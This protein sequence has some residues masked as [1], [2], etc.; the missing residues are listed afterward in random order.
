[1]SKTVAFIGG[2]PASLVSAIKLKELRNDLDIFIIDRNEQLLKKLRMTGNGKCNIAPIKDDV[3]KYNNQN[4]V[5]KLFEAIPFD[6]YLR[7]LAEL[8]ILTK[9][10]KDYGYYPISES[11]PNVAEILINKCKRLGIKIINDFVSDYKI[12][13]D[14]VK[15]RGS[16]ENYSFDHLVIA[17]GGKSHP[18]TG[19][20]GEMFL[21]L[22]KHGYKINPLVPSLCPIKVKE[23]V[24][25]IFG[26]RGDAKVSLYQGNKLIKEEEGELQFKSDALSGICIMNLSKY[27]NPMEIYTIKVDFLMNKNV[28]KIDDITCKEYLLSLVKDN[29]AKYVMKEL[30][31]K[32]DSLLDSSNYERIVKCLSLMTFTF[33]SLYGF[34]DAQVTRGGL[35]IREIDEKFSSIKEENISFIGEILDI[36]GEC[37]GYN[38]RFSISSGLLLS[39]YLL[40]KM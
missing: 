16:K 38:L 40:T 9:A 22:E 32:E 30:K 29:L 1:M 28:K 12:G 24:S 17:T 23:D 31:I 3:S 26:V 8:G 20:K 21:T 5:K 10:I 19:S 15:V 6:E 37:G 34:K 4:F 27:I 39:S 11:A 7:E 36:D 2:G 14:L 33:D 35:D 13:K 18:E 25:S